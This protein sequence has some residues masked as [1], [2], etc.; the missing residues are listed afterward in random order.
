MMNLMKY[1][2]VVF[3]VL[4]GITFSYLLNTLIVLHFMLL[5]FLLPIETYKFKLVSLAYLDLNHAQFF[6][7]VSLVILQTS[8]VRDKRIN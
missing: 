6:T 2:K 7:F 5:Y 1:V 4:K 3:L 8:C